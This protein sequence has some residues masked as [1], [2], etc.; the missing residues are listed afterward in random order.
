M[1]TRLVS[2]LVSRPTCPDRFYLFR[3]RST[4]RPEHRQWE[5]QPGQMHVTDLRTTHNHTTAPHNCTTQPHNCTTQPHR[6]QPYNCT[7]QPH[8]TTTPHRTFLVSSHT[9]VLTG[10][11]V[12]G[13][14]KSLFFGSE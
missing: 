4:A 13:G 2:S 7:A 1:H 10:I 8:R 11:S 12:Q 14:S 3:K 6:T 9:E 5:V